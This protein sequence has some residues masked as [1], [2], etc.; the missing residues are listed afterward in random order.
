MTNMN[1]L[2]LNIPSYDSLKKFYEAIERYSINTEVTDTKIAAIWKLLPPLDRN[3]KSLQER[4]VSR[5]IASELENVFTKES[6]IFKKILP[7]NNPSLENLKALY[8]E[9]ETASNISFTRG[10]QTHRNPSEPSIESMST[11][12]INNLKLIPPSLEQAV[13][14]KSLDLS[15]PSVQIATL[16]DY[17]LNR[18]TTL[19]IHEGLIPLIEENSILFNENIKIIVKGQLSK[20]VPEQIGF[21][22]RTNTQDKRSLTYQFIDQ[23]GLSL[24]RE[25]AKTTPKARPFLKTPNDFFQEL[26]H[27]D[28]T[29]IE[30][31]ADDFERIKKYPSLTSLRLGWNRS[32]TNEEIQTFIHSFDH[33]NELTLYFANDVDV[34]WGDPAFPPQTLNHLRRKEKLQIFQGEFIWTSKA[35]YERSPTPSAPKSLYQQCKSTITWLLRPVI[36]LLKPVTFV[37]KKVVYPVG[38]WLIRKMYSACKAIYRRLIIAG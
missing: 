35:I 5:N 12:K 20:E 27:L 36:W 28:C 31:N 17:L 25:I 2:K 34:L 23:P 11:L 21:L 10:S 1:G 6:I 15:D 33:L 3:V 8:Q 19:T 22:T 4:I 16:P 29:N 7:E 24:T 14:L 26:T 32:I 37:C 13:E 30:L 9:L 18:L 38:S